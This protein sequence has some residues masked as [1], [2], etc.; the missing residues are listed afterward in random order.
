MANNPDRP[1]LKTLWAYIKEIGRELKRPAAWFFIIIALVL[2]TKSLEVIRTHRGQPPLFGEI[3]QPVLRAIGGFVADPDAIDRYLRRIPAFIYQIVIPFS[4][5]WFWFILTGWKKSGGHLVR[6]LREGFSVAWNGFGLS[7]RCIRD[8][9][10]TLLLIFCVMLPF[11]YAFA[12]TESFRRHYPYL[13]RLRFERTE[14]AKIDKGISE[15]TRLIAS[16]A[17]GIQ[18]RQDDNARVELDKL[19]ARARSVFWGSLGLLLLFELLRML[20]MVSWE[21]FF[22][23]FMLQ[24]LLR[25]RL[26]WHAVWIQMLPYVM[27]HSTKPGIE[28]YY[29]IP[30]GVLL[31]VL[32]WKTGSIWPGFLLHFIGAVVFD[33]FA[34]FA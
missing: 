22:R 5:L 10:K 34:M 17:S 23:G 27:L 30:S 24:G 29:T 3:F 33:V 2:A 9:W 6:A 7:L 15:Q 11:I 8:W 28:L 16:S 18:T 14:L 25:L 19:E 31:G 21:F 13:Q 26:G 32:A 12:T 4:A 1:G 20:Y